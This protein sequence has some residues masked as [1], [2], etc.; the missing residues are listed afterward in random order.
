MRDFVDACAILQIQ[1]NLENGGNNECG[2]LL[3][4]APLFFW[5]PNFHYGAP[6]DNEPRNF[7]LVCVIFFFG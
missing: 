5:G 2:I 6:F 1:S 4:C 7:F 3:V